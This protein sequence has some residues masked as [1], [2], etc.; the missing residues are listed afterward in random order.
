MKAVYA[1]N[2]YY[3]KGGA[4]RVFFDET[5]LLTGFGHEVI[6]FSMKSPH[7]RD[8]KHAVFFPDCIEYD[9]VGLLERLRTVPKMVYSL[10]SKVRFSQLL[11]K[12]QPDIVHG[13]NIYGR[14]TSSIVDVAKKAGVPMV[15]TLH[16]YKLICPSYLML[17]HGVTCEKCRNHRFY[18]CAITRCHRDSFLAS[19]V[20]MAESYFNAILKKYEWVSSFLCPSEF[21]KSKCVEMGLPEAKLKVIQNF[22]DYSGFEPKYE[23]GSYMLYAGKLTKEKGVMTLIKAVKGLDFPLKIVGDGEMRGEYEAFVKSNDIKNVEF[24]GFK[25]GEELK[26][27]F[28][29]AAFH[30][31]PSEWYE[32]APMTIIEAFAYGKPVIGSAIGGIPEMIIEG[33]TGFLFESGDHEELREKITFLASNAALITRMGDKAR[34]RVEME[35]NP[36]LH[37]KRLMSTYEETIVH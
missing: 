36:E 32:N 37:Y 25:S 10:D 11:S 18:N 33:E 16:D 29:N 1:N 5:K 27:Y 35:Y 24:L 3:I 6:P 34:K 12:E 2:Y 22:L 9:D 23:G 30:I 8:T 13:H 4:D 28:R 31:V 15:L 7:N 20:Y 17:N 21:M 26:S 19:F 14:L